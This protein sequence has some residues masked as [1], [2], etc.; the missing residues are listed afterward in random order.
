M[1][2]RMTCSSS[3]T[4]TRLTT[5]TDCAPKCCSA[6]TTPSSGRRSSISRRRTGTRSRP[7][8]RMRRVPTR[9]RTRARAARPWAQALE[10]RKVGLTAQSDTV[11]RSVLQADMLDTTMLYLETKAASDAGDASLTARAATALVE[12]L[13]DADGHGLAEAA[14]RRPAAPGVPARLQR[15]RGGCGAERG[16][17]AAAAAL[18]R[19]AGELLR[20]GRRIDGRGAR[21]DAGGAIDGRIDRG[22]ARRHGLQAGGP[23]PAEGEPAVRRELPRHGAEAVRRRPV[24]RARRLQR[25]PRHRLGRAEV[26]GRRRGPRSSRTWSSTR[27]AP[28]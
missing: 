27:R 14:A 15:A 20:A 28:T 11:A 16:R 7:P 23:V 5:S 4:T 1:H 21:P 3:C 26:G 9:V 19:A 10:L 8:S 22:A 24:P 17:P 12:E 6:R 18:A 2:P 25:R 13:K